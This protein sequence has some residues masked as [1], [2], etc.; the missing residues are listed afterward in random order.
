MVAT[1]EAAFVALASEWDALW[2]RVPGA[3][4]FASPHWL[5]PWWRQWGTG[6]PRVAAFR[7]DGRLAAVLPLYVLDEPEGAK[8]LPMGAGTG[9]YLDALA[10]PGTD[11]SAPCSPPPLRPRPTRPSAT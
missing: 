1:N 5:F 7:R 11:V 4:P 3:A 10:E 8:L 2:H 6:T 9:D